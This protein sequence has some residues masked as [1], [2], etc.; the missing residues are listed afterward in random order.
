[1]KFGHSPAVIRIWV[2]DGILG[3]GVAGPADVF[4]VANRLAE[5]SGWGSSARLK[6]IHW[7]VESLTGQHVRTASGQMLG[8][9]EKIEPRRPADA[10][11]VTAPFVADMDEFFGDRNQLRGLA[12][13]LR[14]QHAAGAVVATYCTCSYLL[15]EAELLDGRIATTHWAKAADFACRY[16]RVFLRAHE[17]LTEQDRILCGGAVTSFLNLALRLVEMFLGP[18]LASLTARALLIDT[19]RISQASYSNLLEEHGH[20]DHLVARAQRRM[21][22]TLTQRFDLTALATHLGVSERTLNRRF[23][24]AVGAPPLEY[25]QVL[26]VEVAKRLL[27]SGRDNLEMVSQRVGY[28]DTSTFRQLFKRQT[29]LSP[30]EYQRRFAREL[31]SLAAERN[32]APA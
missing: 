29:G 8:V 18:H 30:R 22:A 9:D 28:G 17:V 19:N 5:N 2:Y 14:H 26:R 23:K 25:L 20:M 3:S 27:E 32:T 1:M 24:Q 6:P 4:T 10:V 15:A 12:S 13:A 11:L 7:R 16:P 21:Q 31:A